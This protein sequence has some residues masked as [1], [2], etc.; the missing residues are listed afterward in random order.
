MADMKL[1]IPKVIGSM[2]NSK[3]G[4]NDYSVTDVRRLTYALRS[5]DPKLRNQLVR[6][7]KEPAKPIQSAVKAAIPTTAP[8]T[9][10]NQ[11]RL[12]WQG[13]V[14][15]KGKIKRP[16]DVQI[17]F[18]TTM[19]GRSLTTSLVRVRVVSPAVVMADMAGR[20]GRYLDSGYKGTG[21]TRPYPYKGGFRVHRL[22][23]QGRAMIRGLGGK[24]SRFVW[25]AAERAVPAAR[26]E[27]EQVVKK[28]AKMVNQKGF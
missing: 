27:I 28:F 22:N 3:I 2:G 5:I 23:G 7:A 11:G 19:S 24:A 26:R 18:R 12:A 9:N 4:P 8:L 17:Q 14:D 21:V 15:S 1:I 20:S 6:E 10:M 25:P 13:S 16:K